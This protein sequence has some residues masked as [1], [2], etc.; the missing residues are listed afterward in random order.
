MLVAYQV[1]S[2]VNTI[3]VMRVLSRKARS[4]MPGMKPRS[5]FS[6]KVTEGASRVPDAVLMITESSAPKKITCA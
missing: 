3:T 1:T 2:A 4:L 6:E 5:T